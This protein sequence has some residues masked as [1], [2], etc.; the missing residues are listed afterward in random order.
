MNAYVLL[1]LSKHNVHST[2]IAPFTRLLVIFVKS[3]NEIRRTI[4]NYDELLKMDTDRT[5]Y[6][7]TECF[8]KKLM[9][10]NINSV[11][12]AQLAMKFMHL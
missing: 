5:K 12:Y 9:L 11:I 7:N 1:K 8:P 4:T 6:I 3:T 10:S 2:G